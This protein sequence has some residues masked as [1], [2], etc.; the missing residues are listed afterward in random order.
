MQLKPDLVQVEKAMDVGRIGSLFIP[1][2]EALEA[3]LRDPCVSSDGNA[4]YLQI[5]TTDWTPP[6]YIRLNTHGHWTDHKN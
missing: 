4:W 6:T 5:V 1:L 2:T 3:S